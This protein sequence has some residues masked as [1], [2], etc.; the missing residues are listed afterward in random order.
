MNDIKNENGYNIINN[1]QN[2]I[3]TE[4]YIEEKDINKKLRIL[5][6]FE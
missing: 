3:V 2:Y 5:N 4:I 6:S 1:D